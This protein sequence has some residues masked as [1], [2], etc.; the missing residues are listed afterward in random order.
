MSADR[1]LVELAGEPAPGDVKLEERVAGRERHA[2]D[3]ADVP[4]ADNQPSGIGI[5][6]DLVDDLGDLID[7]APVGRPPRPPLRAVNRPQLPFGVGPLVPDVDPML[8]Q[9]LDVRLALQEPEQLVDDRLEVQL[10]GRQERE[11]GAQVEAHLMT[12]DGERPGARA[13]LLVHPPV[14]DLFHQIQVLPHR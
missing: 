5:G 7:R 9:V 11:A 2:L 6:L 3:L 12:E 14:Q 1:P 10:L 13:V 8:A 4:G